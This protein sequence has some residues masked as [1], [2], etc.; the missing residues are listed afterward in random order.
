MNRK[1]LLHHAGYYK[2]IIN[3]LICVRTSI[4]CAL[5]L[6]IDVPR[7]RD[8]KKNI[9]RSALSRRARGSDKAIQTSDLHNK[10]GGG[11]IV[12]K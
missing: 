9:Q 5:S 2:V 12:L 11:Y 8:L 3:L 7:L 10:R 4:C 1:G 6:A